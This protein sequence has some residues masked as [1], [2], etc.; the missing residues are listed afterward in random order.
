M[1][2]GV[3]DQR[4]ALDR[5]RAA[6][7]EH[8]APPRA[9]RQV[10]VEPAA[11]RAAHGPAALTNASPAMRAP[12]PAAARRCATSVDVEAAAPPHAGNARRATAP[13]AGTPASGCSRRT[14]PR[15][16]RPSEPSATPSVDSHGNRCVQRVRRR[17]ARRRRRARAAAR[18]SARASPRPAADARIQVA[19]LDQADV[20]RS[21]STASRSPMPRRN[22]MP[23]RESS[24]LTASRTAGGSS[25]PT[26]PT[27]P[28]RNSGRAR[29]PSRVPRNAGSASVKDAIALPIT[30]PPTMTMSPFMFG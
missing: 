23:K 13:C 28:V 25:S 17:A 19:L 1:P 27:K 30:P 8:A 9:H 12:S 24:M 6:E 20:G 18:D 4:T 16:D 26:A 7:R 3:D 10:D 11:T 22:S 29:P 14:S 21:P 15:R 2:A 5:R